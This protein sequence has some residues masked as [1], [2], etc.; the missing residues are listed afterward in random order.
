MEQIAR[1]KVL[2][3]RNKNLFRDKPKEKRK[4]KTLNEVKNIYIIEKYVSKRNKQME[5]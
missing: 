4:K 2:K 5:K 3:G 1:D